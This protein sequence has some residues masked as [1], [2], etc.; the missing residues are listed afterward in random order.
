MIII[1]HYVKICSIARNLL[2]IIIRNVFR[3]TIE[4]LFNILFVNKNSVP[5][6]F[7]LLMEVIKR[8]YKKG[9][10]VLINFLRLKTKKKNKREKC[11][12]LRMRLLPHMKYKFQKIIF[13]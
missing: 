11:L 9:F 8:S 5:I 2:L 1:A 6:Y 13:R 12:R 4:T 7:V 10:D 3:N